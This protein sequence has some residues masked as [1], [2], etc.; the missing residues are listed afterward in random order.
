MVGG[1]TILAA[2]D[3]TTVLLCVALIVPAG[4]LNVAYSRWT[5][6]MSRTLHDTLEREVDV[7]HRGDPG[8]IRGHYAAVAR[9][10]V[11]LSDGEAWNF[12][13]ME[14]FV[15]ALIAASL[16]RSCGTSTTT[17]GEILA[18]LRYVLMFIG[19]LDSLPLLIQQTSRLRDVGRRCLLDDAAEDCAS[20]TG[21]R[22]FYA[23]FS[24][25]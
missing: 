10:Q 15:M 5:L 3:V 1:L 6:A 9:C 7:I 23:A 17:P 25:P 20:P 24:R 19:G 18:A 14:V 22:P 12:G 8:D 4:V 11:R 16:I 21:A 13:A 2:Y